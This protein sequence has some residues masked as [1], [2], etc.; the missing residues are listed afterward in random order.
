MFRYLSRLCMALSIVLA[1]LPSL[2]A[3]ADNALRQAAMLHKG[4]DTAKAVTIWR[5]RSA[6]I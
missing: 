4:G 5:T 1:A 6:V 2:A 3:E